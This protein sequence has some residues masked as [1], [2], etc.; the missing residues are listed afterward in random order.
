MPSPTTSCRAT[1]S[2]THSSEVPSRGS[3]QPSAIPPSCRADAPLHRPAKSRHS[4][5]PSKPERF[6]GSTGETLRDRT[7]VCLASSQREGDDAPFSI[8]ECVNLRVAPSARNGQQPAF[9]S[10]FSRRRA[11]GFASSRSFCMSADRP[12]PASSRKRFS[13]SRAAPSA[14]SG[15]RSSSAHDPNPPSQRESEP[16]CQ[17]KTDQKN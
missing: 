5:S 11:V 6:T 16:Y 13:Y 2:P 7:I 14:R 15:Y 8:C 12:F 10:P 3:N 17:T 1:A 9:T 4:K